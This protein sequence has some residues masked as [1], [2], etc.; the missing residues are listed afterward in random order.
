MVKINT[1]V[2]LVCLAFLLLFL[3]CIYQSFVKELARF[4]QSDG[5]KKGLLHHYSHN[6]NDTENLEEDI[7]LDS[8][9]ENEEIKS[10]LP[11]HS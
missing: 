3:W 2:F 11:C 7:P 10:Y 6:S 5:F 8:S 1:V 9:V 4:N